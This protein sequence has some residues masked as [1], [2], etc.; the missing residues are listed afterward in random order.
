MSIPV[1][2]T[3]TQPEP[4]PVAE[5]TKG[6]QPQ[7][8]RL[9]GRNCLPTTL[10]LLMGPPCDPHG[11]PGC[12]DCARVALRR[13]PWNVQPSIYGATAMF[14]ARLPRQPKSKLTAGHGWACFQMT[15]TPSNWQPTRA[16]SVTPYPSR[17]VIF[18]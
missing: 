15:A 5:S 8:P 3:P 9:K 4:Q 18:V 7:P 16:E 12:A 14:A 13:L 6:W 11:Q 1:Q 10:D 17:A 2:N